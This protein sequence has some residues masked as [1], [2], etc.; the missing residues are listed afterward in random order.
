MTFN[1]AFRPGLSVTLVAAAISVSGC[2]M[3][4]HSRPVEEPTVPAVESGPDTPEHQLTATEAAACWPIGCL[5][6]HRLD[7]FQLVDHA[8]HLGVGG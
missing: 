3:F 1:R 2:A 4:G 6:A 8:P 7:V 5:L